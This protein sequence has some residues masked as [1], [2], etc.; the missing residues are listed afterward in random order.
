[1]SVWEK[2]RGWYIDNE[3]AYEVWKETVP[4]SM[5]EFYMNSIKKYVCE[6]KAEIIENMHIR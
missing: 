5:G 3:K 6:H 1:M 4:A 2:D